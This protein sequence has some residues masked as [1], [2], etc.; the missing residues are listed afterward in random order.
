M[1]IES[2]IIFLVVGA[3]A[4]WLAGQIVK[5]GGYG[6]V[7]DMVVGIL[8]ALIG[9]YATGPAKRDT[10]PRLAELVRRSTSFR[11]AQAPSAGTRSACTC[12]CRRRR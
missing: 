6:V 11:F 10:T 3:I 7:G 1:T 5:G 12:R 9:G 4:G 2:I 8:G